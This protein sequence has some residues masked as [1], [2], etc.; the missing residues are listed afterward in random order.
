MAMGG[1]KSNKQSFGQLILLLLAAFFC[2][3]RA[4]FAEPPNVLFIVVD[5]LRPELGCYGHGTIHTPC[6][7]RL[8]QTGTLFYHAYCQQAVCAPSRATVLSGCRPDTTGIYGLQT[9]VRQAMPKVLTLPQLFQ[10]NG[11]TTVG[12]GKIYHHDMDDAEHW[13]ERNRATSVRYFLRE[14]KEIIRKKHAQ[15]RA[16]KQKRRYWHGCA[17]ATECADVSDDVYLDGKHA[18]MAVDALRRYHD[19]PLFLAVGFIRPHLPFCAPKKYWDLYDRESIHVPAADRPQASPAIA[20]DNW[21]E[22]RSYA[23]IPGAGPISQQKS[24]ELIHGYFACVSYIDALVGNVLKELERHGLKEKTIVVLWGDHGWKLGEYGQWCKH[25]NFEWDTRAP[26]ICRAPGTL[27]GTT[28]RRLVE[29]V[30]I[31]PTLADLCGLEIPEHCEGVSMA[32][33]LKNPRLPWKKAAFSQYPRA[34]NVM[35][36]SVRTEQW[37]FTQWVDRDNGA[38]IARELYDHSEGSLAQANL[39]GDRSRAQQVEDL[40]AILTA[41]W[42]AA[43]PPREQDSD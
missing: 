10:Q 1:A 8:A 25:T 13:T 41:G 31:Y 42:R 37:R 24:R 26:L 18:T 21:G 39:A 35:G 29:F 19:R 3:M 28:C 30:D 20:Y 5:D 6:I 17:N 16:N 34:G 23:D 4:A 43:L 36:Y 9:P 7:D 2:T 40:A 11:Y 33:L 22:L 32:P 12:I 27:T 15:A 14:N 38:V